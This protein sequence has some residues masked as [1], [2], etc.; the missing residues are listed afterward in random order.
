ML[1]AYRL[2]VY[3]RLRGAMLT[4]TPKRNLFAKVD[5]P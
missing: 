1:L 2:P 3:P 4:T 5:L